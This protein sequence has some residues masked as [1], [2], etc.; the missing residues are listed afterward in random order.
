MIALSLPVLVVLASRRHFA[1]LI[2]L[3]V[4]VAALYVAVNLAKA[5]I[6]RPRPAGGLTDTEGSSFPSGH[7]AYSTVWIALAVVVARALPGLASRA[8][9]VGGAVAVAAVVGLSRIYLRAHYWSDVAAG[10]ALGAAILGLCAAVA[11][12]VTHIRNNGPREPVA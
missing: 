4:G 9:L 5:G 12:V 3:V 6:D 1:E 2:S 8:A 10:W 11:L 7:A